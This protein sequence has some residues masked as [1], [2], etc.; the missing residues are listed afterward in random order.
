MYVTTPDGQRIGC[1][2]PAELFKV[3]E[4]LNLTYEEVNGANFRPKEKVPWWWSKKKRT[5]HEQTKKLIEERRRLIEERTG[6]QTFCVCLECKK[7]CYLDLGLEQKRGPRDKR[8]CPTCG[9]EKIKTL[10]ELIG[11]PCPLCGEGKI[12]EIVS[13]AIA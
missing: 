11:E 8:Q 1:P 7:P 2:H 6:K 9:S 12:E 10:F 5:D 3:A 13:G 4:V